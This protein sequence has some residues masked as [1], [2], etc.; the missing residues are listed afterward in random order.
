[1]EKK[2]FFQTRITIVLIL[3]LINDIKTYKCGAGQLKINP[4]ILKFNKTYYHKISNQ[5]KDTG[6]TPIRIGMDY[7]SFS[8]PS[9]MSEEI[10]NNV[11]NLITETIQEF[12]KFLQVQHVDLQLNSAE[13]AIKQVC[14]VEQISSDYKNFLVNY[15]V[16]VFPSFF[17]LGTSILAQAGACLA[18]NVDSNHVRPIAGILRINQSLS[19]SKKNTD[20]YLKN[21]LLH[22]ITHILIFDP[23]LLNNLGM[24]KTIDSI[25][26]VTSANV[27]SKAKQHFKCDSIIGIPLENQGNES[28]EGCHWEARYMLGDYMISTDY[29]DNVISDITLALFEDSGIYKVNYFSGGLFKYGKNKGCDFFNKKCITNNQA[30]SEEFCVTSRQPMCAQSRTVKGYCGIY[31]Y[32]Q[33]TIPSQYQYFSQSNIGGFVPADFCPVASLNST[34]EEQEYLSSSCNKGTSSLPS[35]YGEEIS[36]NSFC[37]ISSL[38]PSSSSI[39]QDTTI[40]IC[41]RVECDSSNKKIIVHIGSSTVTCPR[42]GGTLSNLSGFKGSI[43]CP[44]YTDI[45]TFENNAIC[46]EMFDCLSKKVITDSNTY[47][48]DEGNDNYTYVRKSYSSYKKFNFYLIFLLLFLF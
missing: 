23:K 7:T 15:D 28:S 46:N 35:D 45:C 18:F 30:I 21:L 29:I 42:E 10:F 1:M 43:I 44:K 5:V 27:L 20:I 33:I 47:N 22:E 41:Y 26:Y 6:Y 37:F 39:T 31:S 9:S 38:L 8:K 40:S 32:S 34:N 36:E 3:M 4:K 48:L 17:D 11:K 13:N 24:I 19:F 25:S 14:Q 2:N 12:Q 16:I